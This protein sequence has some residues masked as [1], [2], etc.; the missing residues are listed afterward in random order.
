MKAK[1][2]TLLGYLILLYQLQIFSIIW[3]ERM[4]MYNICLSRYLLCLVYLYLCLIYRWM[5]WGCSFKNFHFCLQE[6]FA[7]FKNS[8]RAM[9]RVKHWRQDFMPSNTH[10]NYEAQEV[11]TILLFCR[12]MKVSCCWMGKIVLQCIFI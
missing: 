4:I 10:E 1:H 6:W 3:D 7:V 12:V 8:Y 5:N 11:P 2:L 9:N